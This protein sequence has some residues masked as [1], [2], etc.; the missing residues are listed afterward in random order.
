MAMEKQRD[1][2]KELVK[3]CGLVR[4]SIVHTTRKC[5][6]AQ[7]EC[8][9]GKQHPFCYLS[10]SSAGSKNKIQ[11]V[12]PSE[13]KAFERAVAMYER[14]WAI[15]EELTELNIKEIKEN[16]NDGRRTERP[17]GKK[18]S[19][20]QSRDR[21]GAENIQPE[22]VGEDLQ[23]SGKHTGSPVGTGDGRHRGGGAAKDGGRRPNRKAR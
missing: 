8:A 12:K 15:I 9:K 1:L 16:G 7:C 2:A 5:G 11:Y 20:T 4:G 22:P 19:R 10:R 3:L 13:E 14:A 23:G 18:A 21:P 17:G 6:R